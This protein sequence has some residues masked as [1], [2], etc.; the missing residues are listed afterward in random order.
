MIAKEN[1]AY[2]DDF[3]SYIEAGA[4]RSASLVVPLVGRLLNVKSVMDVGCGRGV[5]LSQ[6]QKLGVQDVIGVDG[7]YVNE[8]D[9][10]ISPDKFIKRDLTNPVNLGRRFDLVQSLEVGEHLPE[11]SSDTFV[12]SLAAHGDAILFSAAVPGQGGEF[13]VNEKPYEFWRDKFAAHGFRTFDWLRLRIVDISDIEP[14][15]RY[16]SLLF[17]RGTALRSLPAEFLKT[18]IPNE[19]RIPI[20]SKFSWRARNR[21]L[22]CLPGYFVH[23]LAQLKHKTVLLRRALIGSG[24]A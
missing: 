4:R 19:C 23:R 16:N 6:W 3:F 9:L 5:W 18:E 2:R 10:A 12:A 20:R 8:N 11:Q 1:Y 17:V 13:H 15:Y 21:I 7:D 22:A 24:G 14:W